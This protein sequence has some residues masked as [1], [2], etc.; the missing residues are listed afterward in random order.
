MRLSMMAALLAV[1]M[2]L[3]GAHAAVLYTNP[4]IIDAN[5]TANCSAFGCIASTHW[6]AQL[7]TLG[8]DSTVTTLSFNSYLG[9]GSAS[10]TTA[11]WK[12]MDDDGSG[13]LPGT[14]IA[15]GSASVTA[16]AGPTGP[17]APTANYSFTIPDLNLAAGD[18]Y[19]A[20]QASGAPAFTEYLSRGI[21]PDG[22]VGSADDMA[23]W[24]SNYFGHPSI[25]VTIEGSAIESAP[26]PASLALFGLA[27]AGL[28]QARRRK[29]G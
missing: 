28:I 16:S 24:L 17:F 15:S 1:P 18:Y 19:F 2:S 7:F 9:N 23:S 4:P 26:E 8:S 11:N 3:S 21:A 20:L 25:A 14:V 10:H 29:A 22:G 5:Q 6:G 27:V 13:D 12:I